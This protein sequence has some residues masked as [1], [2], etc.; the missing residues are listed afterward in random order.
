[1]QSLGDLS[2]TNHTSV[3][4]I[5]VIEDDADIGPSLYR[6]SRKRHPIIH[7]SSLMASK[8]LKSPAISYQISSSSI[9]CC[10]I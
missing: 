6:L 10:L 7:S 5:L 1:M 2:I 4:T 8:P 9:T 3:K